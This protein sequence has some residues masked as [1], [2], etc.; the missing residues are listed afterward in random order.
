MMFTAVN[1]PSMTC[2]FPKELKHLQ[3][4]S[5]PHEPQLFSEQGNY[6]G[7]LLPNPKTIAQDWPLEETEDLLQ[8]E[9]GVHALSSAVNPGS[10][11]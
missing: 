10:D 1:Q 2:S 6:T 9:E 3:A 11:F 8:E 5:H 4:Q 7:T